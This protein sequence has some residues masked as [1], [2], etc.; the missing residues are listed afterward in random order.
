MPIREDAATR[1]NS[2]A[3]G[4][5]ARRRVGRCTRE[6]LDAFLSS[7]EPVTAAQ[8]YYNTRKLV[9]I[10]AWK[11]GNTEKELG[12]D[13][14]R[15][16]AMCSRIVKSMEGTSND[17][18]TMTNVSSWKL[19]TELEPLKPALKQ[20]ELKF[21]AHLFARGLSANLRCLLL[22]AVVR[23]RP[24]LGRASLTAVA[25]LALRP[26]GDATAT[27]TETDSNIHIGS[28]NLKVDE[29][30]NLLVMHFL[31]VPAVVH[32]L[33][34]IAP[35]SLVLLRQYDV[36]GRVV[37]LL[38]NPQKLRIV[39]NVLEASFAL[40]L[41][42]NLVDLAQ[43]M[44]LERPA[45]LESMAA[46]FITVGTMILES[47]QQYVVKKQSAL[48]HYH[49]LLGWFSQKVDTGH[50]EVIPHIKTQLQL[51]W[52]TTL[53]QLLFKPL[54]VMQFQ[55]DASSPS[56][57]ET[58]AKA[59]I[60]EVINLIRGSGSRSSSALMKISSP[61]VNSVAVTCHLYETAISSLSE[62]RLDILTGL[63]FQS[64]DL[65][66]RL[67]RLISALGGAASGKAKAFLDL[68]QQNVKANSL[69]FQ[70]LKL[71]CNCTSHL[72][73]VLDDSEL[74]D[75]QR[76]FYLADLVAISAFLNIFLYKIIVHQLLD[77][78]SLSSCPLFTSAHSLLML[79]Y[80][81]DSRRN[82]APRDH[83]LVKAKFST[84]LCDLEAGK[85]WAQLVIH[86]LP[87]VLPHR[88]RVQLFRRRVQ[89][90]RMCVLN[91]AES[92]H[93]SVHRTRIVE[94]GFQQLNALTPQELKGTIRVRFVNLQ[95]LDEAGI[96]Q[97][98]VFK[99]FL[100]E[101][102]KRVFDPA[103]NLFR[104]T[105]EQHLYPSATSYINENHLALFEF[106][107][108]MLAKAVYEGIVV[109]VPFATF[110]L[111]QILGLHQNI[112]YYSYID[113]LPSLDE[114]LYSSLTYIKNYKGD[115]QDLSLFFC[116]DDDSLGRIITHEL[117]PAGRTMAVTNENKIRYIHLTAQY[118]MQTQIAEQTKAFIRGFRSLIRPE[119]VAMFSAPELQRLISGD[120]AG[121]D[122]ADLRANTKYFGGFHNNHRVIGW[123]WDIL[124]SDFSPEE[125]RLF[126]KFV[127][128]CSKPPLL[129]FANLEPP[130]SIRC[131]E[132][133]DDQDTG[134][135]LASFMRTFFRVRKKDPVDR[136]PT[137]STCFNLLKLPN[138]Q[139]KDT[140][141]DKLRYAIS[142][143]TGFELS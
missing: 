91:G 20:L 110:F 35:D 136:L 71:F 43:Q 22:A 84:L 14:D 83:W 89:H 31:S 66:P 3:R 85:P 44:A 96:D 127:T 15:L 58:S 107:G 88:D 10:Y 97:D 21:V 23:Q 100:E 57:V 105:S 141:R 142:S 32:Q 45:K 65:L 47:C 36:L 126:L 81:R 93:I 4:F 95:G 143:N 51:L 137:S 86:K 69:E 75:E 106:V 1:I 112:Q 72:I 19:R 73:V 64:T 87:H 122:L 60:N 98:G 30:T 129:G 135:T 63:S 16:Q 46:G 134:D 77:L 78:K 92:T 37:A 131:V 5:L 59:Q 104:T 61:E 29:A 38:E 70:I 99:E 33:H 124:R 133:A 82:F 116:I 9:Y 123:L 74:Y 55:R 28:T 53:S 27:N 120:D 132:V 119:W 76:P 80:R 6:E 34:S 111:S 118:K 41:L 121:I 2:V 128:S 108:K 8:L 40:C 101:T 49:P 26:L 103:L 94:D 62:L 138:Y 50:Q 12:K 39:F 113:E 54:F 114:Q 42:A 52:G 139:R 102:I 109:D 140:L 130:F 79:L 90:E 68:L 7:K 25:S 48:S 17:Q 67:W 24:L 56:P 125:C 18:V 11:E 117:V 13:N 115:V